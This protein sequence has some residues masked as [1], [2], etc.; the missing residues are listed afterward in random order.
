[1]FFWESLPVWLGVSVYNSGKDH[2]AAAFEN[3]TER[4]K[5]E[6]ALRQS[7]NRLRM[8]TENARVG[9]VMLNGER[10]YTFANAAYVRNPRS[11]LGKYHW[12]AHC[13]RA[14]AAL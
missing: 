10:R 13:R 7:E 11:A 6:E 3:I 8:V 4:K 14:G 5:A 9:L 2:F 12:A 1:M